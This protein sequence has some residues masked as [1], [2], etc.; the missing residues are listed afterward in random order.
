VKPDNGDSKNLYLHFKPNASTSG[1]RALVLGEVLWDLFPA[2]VRLGGAALNFAAH[3]KRLGHEPLLVSAVGTD[4]LGDEAVQAISTLGVDPCFIQKT[5]RFKTGTAAVQ[6]GPGDQ[7]SFVIERPAAYDAVQLSDR[8]IEQIINWQ[9]EWLYYGTLFS[10]SVTG[11][12][13]L[14]RLQAAVPQARRFYD[15]NLRPRCDSQ[16]LVL[17]LLRAASVVKLNEEELRAVHKFTELPAD[18]EGF[19]HAGVERFGWNAVCVTLGAKGCAMLAVGE[20]VEAQ[21]H[22][23]DVADTVGAGDAFAAA[24]MHGIISNWRAAEIAEFSNRVGALVASVHGA[25]PNWT[26]KEVVDS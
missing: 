12:D 9:P 3:I 1:R 6:L 4:E 26:L 19:C 2:S 14:R 25:I 13:V 10:S 18:T 11:R 22:R 5:E 23:V 16:E 7:T 20:Y 8:H 24:F 15:L 21:G 17:E